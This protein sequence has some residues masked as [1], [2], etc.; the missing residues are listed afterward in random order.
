MPKIQKIMYTI[1]TNKRV[2]IGLVLHTNQYTGRA[3]SEKKLFKV[4]SVNIDVQ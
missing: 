2:N 4:F 3:S 1:S